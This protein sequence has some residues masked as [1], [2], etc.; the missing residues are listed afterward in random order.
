MAEHFVILCPYCMGEIDETTEFC[1]HCK[2]D[3]RNDAPFEMTWEE[4]AQA[5]RMPCIFCGKPRLELANTC[6]FCGK[7]Q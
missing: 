1:P 7:R 2:Q 6:P 3:T 5:S 4:Y